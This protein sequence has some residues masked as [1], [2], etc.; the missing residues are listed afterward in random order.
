M[1]TTL[2]VMEIYSA[3]QGEGTRVGCPSVFIRL[4]GC[5]LRCT[6]CD[7]SYSINIDEAR[8]V[9]SPHEIE[10]LFTRFLPV[11]LAHTI[12]DRFPFVTDLVISGGEP[13]IHMSPLIQFVELMRESGKIV[14][15]ETNGTCPPPKSLPGEGVHL[16]SVSA[17][18][19]GSQTTI[20]LE[21]RRRVQWEKWEEVADR[22][23]F[24][25]V[26]TNLASDLPFV[27]SVLTN[28]PRLSVAP[29]V[30]VPNGDLF[31]SDHSSG[32]AQYDAIARLVTNSGDWS[33]FD[34]RV[35]PQLHLLAH[36]RQRYT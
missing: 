2:P 5:N 16:W 7:T 11:D 4:F 24:K 1:S 25:F 20:D 18:P 17:K 22:S 15:V 21:S 6:W 10:T 26:I 3:V 8:A 27:L 28:H 29:I 12:L 9:L 32:W 33:S 36:G 14:T 23:Q 35:L 34:V 19:P 13:L 30:L 31:S